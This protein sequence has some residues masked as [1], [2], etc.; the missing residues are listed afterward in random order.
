MFGTPKMDFGNHAPLPDSSAV[1]FKSQELR[2]EAYPWFQRG[3]ILGIL[4]KAVVHPYWIER[5]EEL[6]HRRSKL[7]FVVDFSQTRSGEFDTIKSQLTLEVHDRDD[8]VIFTGS[9]FTSTVNWAG[10]TTEYEAATIKTFKP[11][12]QRLM[13]DSTVA[14][15]VRSQQ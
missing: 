14:Q 3:L 5:L 4:R 8:R 15:Y 7:L 10:E 13:A 6:P 11:V 9:N 1:Y 2:E 12:M